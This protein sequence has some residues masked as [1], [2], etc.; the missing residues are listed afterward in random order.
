MTNTKTLLMAGAIAGAIVSGLATADEPRD[1]PERRIH[2]LVEPTAELKAELRAV[3][4][5]RRPVEKRA[6]EVSWGASF[7]TT[8]RLD[9]IVDGRLRVS[10]PMP[11][12]QAARLLGVRE[13]QSADEIADNTLFQGRLYTSYPLRDVEAERGLIPLVGDDLVLELQRG[14]FEVAYVVAWRKP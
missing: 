6:P 2:L 12:D 10:V 8:A 1:P 14:A 4:E 3:Q 13:V 7:A 11:P 5:A 9:A